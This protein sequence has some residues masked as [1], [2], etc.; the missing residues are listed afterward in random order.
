VK[1]DFKSWWHFKLYLLQRDSVLRFLPLLLLFPLE[2]L[3]LNYRSVLLVYSQ[4]WI[5]KVDEDRESIA[6]KSFLLLLL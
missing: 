3:V 6:F 4:S 1:E 2:Y 5:Q